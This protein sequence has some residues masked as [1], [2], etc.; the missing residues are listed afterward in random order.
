MLGRGKVPLEN[1]FFFP[2]FFLERTSR[3]PAGAALEVMPPNSTSM[4]R[5]IPGLLQQGLEAGIG[6]H[7]LSYA[8]AIPG[9]SFAAA[10]Q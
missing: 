6:V 2:Q 10:G 5:I 7:R 8:L 4:L 1:R 3:F 9:G